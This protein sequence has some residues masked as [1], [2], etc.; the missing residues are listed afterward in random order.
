ETIRETYKKYG[1]LVDTHT[2]DGIKVGLE[3]RESDIPLI[4]LE[5]ALPVKFSDSIQEAI[6]KEPEPIPGFEDLE[7]LPQRFIVMDKD[8]NEV[9]QFISSKVRS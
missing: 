9:K 3:N 2:A 7:K 5:T 1:V 6:G 8:V 4:C